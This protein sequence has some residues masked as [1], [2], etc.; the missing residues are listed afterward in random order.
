MA[1]NE[2]ETIKILTFSPRCLVAK[3][4][5]VCCGGETGE[6]V[7]IRIRE[8]R[9]PDDSTDLDIRLN[10]LEAD[11][12]LPLNFDSFRSDTYGSRTSRLQSALEKNLT[13][14]SKKMA[15]DRVN[16]VTMWF[17]PDKDDMPVGHYTEPVAVLANNDKTVVL[18]G[19]D[20]FESQEK[21]EPLDIVHYPDYVNRSIM[22]P[23]GRLLISILDDPF[24]YVHRRTVKRDDQGPVRPHDGV[25]FHW[26]QCNKVMLKSQRRGDVSDSR[27]S[28]AACFS[29]SGAYLAVGTQYGTISVFDTQ[30]LTDPAAD[31][32]LSSFTSSRPM[33]GWG[34]VR[35]MAFCPGPF[36]LLAWTED[37]GRVGVADVRSGFTLQQVL[38][39]SAEES[40]E[41]VDAL[42]RD[43]IDP[44]LYEGRG[45]RSY[46]SSTGL[47]S[48]LNLND[49][50]RRRNAGERFGPG[51]DDL[52]VLEATQNESRRREQA[53]RIAARLADHSN[54]A[55]SN[56]LASFP[57]ELYANRSSGTAD[58]DT[59]A[60]GPRERSS[61]IARALRELQQRDRDD[62][63]NVTRALTEWMRDSR[64]RSQRSSQRDSERGERSRGERDAQ[65]LPPLPRRTTNLRPAENAAQSPRAAGGS[66]S[67]LTSSGGW[68][69]LEA[70]Y[71]ITVEN[72]NSAEP[73]ESAQPETTQR[74]LPDERERNRSGFLPFINS[75]AIREMDNRL[76]QQRRVDTSVHE[77]PP[78]PDNTA[79]ISWSEDGRVL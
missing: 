44:R 53:E 67:G 6:F 48:T 68:A 34:A 47:N 62:R 50:R 36:D 15:R 63:H 41:H 25:Q 32:L 76:A 5:W 37:R 20:N 3:K 12:R 74:D 16:C 10:E 75:V 14:K 39:I 55:N 2:R 73:R 1:T 24:L 26:E 33:A 60:R 7:A 59:A 72:N 57:W 51:Y 17:P 52:L 21:P 56:A 8:S 30:R 18:V 29:S 9:F 66:R 31:P 54:S 49:M 58:N 70:L 64:D 22:S 61:S 40:F 23:D 38:D 19:L 65:V 45:E 46:Y 79:G 42:D 28:F 27:G 78:E 35:D 4:G 71:N 43:A 13:A 69:D 11:S 77:S